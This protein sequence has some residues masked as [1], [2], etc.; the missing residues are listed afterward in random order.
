MLIFKKIKNFHADEFS[1][2]SSQNTETRSRHATAIVMMGV[3]GAEF[4]T[5]IEGK[6]DKKTAEGFGVTNYAHA[7]STSEYFDMY[8]IIPCFVLA[9]GLQGS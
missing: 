2:S 6:E 5:N 4:G 7:R 3:I 1:S 8:T 9:R